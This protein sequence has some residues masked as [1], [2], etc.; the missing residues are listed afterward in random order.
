MIES[1]L[2]PFTYNYMTNAILVSALVGGT[3]AFLSSYLI[4]KGWALMGDALAHSIVPGV[5]LAYIL[6]LPYVIG[7]FFAGALAASSIMFVKKITRLKE[8]TILG[9]VFTTFFAFG[10]LLVSIKPTAIDLQ[11][12]ILGNI[13][14]VSDSDIVQLVF[15][16][17]TCLIL[18]ILKWRDF[19]AIFFDENH[20]RTIALPVGR[21]KILFFALLSAATVSALQT[22]GACLVIAMVITPGAT[23]YLLTERFHKMII[24][25]VFIGTTTSALGAYLSYFLNTNPG[26]LIVTLQ[27]FIFIVIFFL[28]PK[29]GVFAQRRI[30]RKQ[31]N[32]SALPYGDNITS[33]PVDNQSIFST[34]TGEQK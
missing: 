7:A 15:I 18:L 25:S 4:L 2:E 28:A 34:N 14:A 6:G 26:G 11:A 30:M 1:L 12:I 17:T 16:C 21:L 5:A 31:S 13:L 32:N 29:H 23:A 24:L 27:T 3:C 33:L 20:A 9:L 19:M 10:L 8:D 22:V